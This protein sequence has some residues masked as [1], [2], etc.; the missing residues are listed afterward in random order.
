ML[1]KCQQEVMNT[2]QDK[3]LLDKNEL[4]EGGQQ[5]E[6]L[7]SIV[8]EQSLRVTSDTFVQNKWE[9]SALTLKS[10]LYIDFK[11]YPSQ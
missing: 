10:T 4:T 3:S 5:L 9:T 6:L 8:L 1:K 11:T 7:K 2:E